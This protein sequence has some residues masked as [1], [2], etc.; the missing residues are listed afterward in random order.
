MLNPIDLTGKVMRRIQSIIAGERGVLLIIILLFA[1]VGIWFYLNKSGF[2]ISRKEIIKRINRVNVSIALLIV[3]GIAYGFRL[4]LMP[5]SP[6]YLVLTYQRT[7]EREFSMPPEYWSVGALRVGDVSFNSLG[8]KVAEVTDIKKSYWGADR[9]NFQ[10]TVKVDAIR[11][12]VTGEYSMDGKPLMIGN[13][14]ILPLGRTQFNGV[15]SDIYRDEQERLGRYRRAK[16]TVQL[17]GRFYEPWQAEALRDFVV[18]DTKGKIVASVKNIVIEPGEY[19]FTT[20]NGRTLLLR[21]PIKKDV[22]M[23]LELFDVLCTDQTCYFEEF[24][25]IKIGHDLWITS[26]KVVLPGA[27]IMNFKIEYFD[28]Q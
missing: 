6:M 7:I 9:E 17:K 15:I 28:N 25:P 14:L 18:R 1:I 2:K 4:T 21:D 22:T 23:T 10:V 3:I 11:N 26:D 27:N 13:K 19:T 20:D 24:K 8:K 12:N 5:A 16:A